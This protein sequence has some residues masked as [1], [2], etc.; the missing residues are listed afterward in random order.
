MIGSFSGLFD[1]LFIPIKP[2]ARSSR[3]NALSV[4]YSIIELTLASRKKKEM[5]EQN[6]PEKPQFDYPSLLKAYYELAIHQQLG[7][8]SHSLFLALLHKANNLRFRRYFRIS[9]KELANLAVLSERGVRMARD[10]LVQ[11]TIQKL[12]LILYW[13]GHRGR[14]PTYAIIYELLDLDADFSQIEKKIEELRSVISNLKELDSSISDLK[15]LRSSIDLEELHSSIPHLEELN[16]AK[17]SGTSFPYPPLRGTTCRDHNF[18]REEGDLLPPLPIN[19]VSGIANNVPEGGAE[20]EAIFSKREKTEEEIR[21]IVVNLAQ[22]GV[23]SKKVA[24]QLA[25][26][27]TTSFIYRHI[28]QLKHDFSDGQRWKDSGGILVSRIRKGESTPDFPPEEYPE[29]AYEN[30]FGGQN[31]T[32]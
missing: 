12:P 18:K 2:K 23:K 24:E 14:S 3:R 1:F 28:M 10:R 4:F 6:K 17:D 5:G 7:L 13:E 11:F 16:A 20:G 8:A 19:N 29:S 26:N 32:Y 25:K 27:Y 30:K 22:H 21:D 31:G 9:G 15:E